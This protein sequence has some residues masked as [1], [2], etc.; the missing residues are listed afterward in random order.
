MLAAAQREGIELEYVQMTRQ[1]T[2]VF[3]GEKHGRWIRQTASKDR[4]AGVTANAN[5]AVATR[6]AARGG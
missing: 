1:H 2:Y 6:P 4:D 5:A 3:T